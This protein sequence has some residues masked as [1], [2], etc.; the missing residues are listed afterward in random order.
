MLDVFIIPILFSPA[1]CALE[2]YKAANFELPLQK[3][4]KIFGNLIF[5]PR[6]LHKSDPDYHQIVKALPGYHIKAEIQPFLDQENVREDLIIVESMNLGICSAAGTNI[7]S[8]GDAV[9]RLAPGFLQTD[10]DACHFIMKHEISHIKNNDNFTIPLVGSVCSTATAVF[11]T[12]TMPWLAATQLTTFV[13]VSAFALFSLR[14]DGKADDLAI[15]NS[16]NEELLAG[17]RFFMSLTKINIENRRTFWEK[18][19]ITPYGN[20]LFDI[21][22]PSL[23]NRIEKIEKVLARKGVLIN[24]AQEN[25][26]FEKLKV[27]MI[28]NRNKLKK[29]AE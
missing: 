14:R 24:H 7:F 8:K 15:E 27:F 19:A 29:V 28:E 20:N 1:S 22:H 10:K 26:K 21:E 5:E 13:G 18:I 11:A 9:V 17:R 6:R 23:T 3:Q 16:S 2:A 25:P 12:L 4:S